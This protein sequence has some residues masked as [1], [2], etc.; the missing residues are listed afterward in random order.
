MP[1]PGLLMVTLLALG[2][3]VA[4]AGAP[5]WPL[6]LLLGSTSAPL[7][8]FVLPGC[9]GLAACSGAARASAAALLVAGVVLAGAAALRAALY[10]VPV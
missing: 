3:A 4:A 7:L 1:G 6:L 2:G 5:L 10:P 9:C 8:A